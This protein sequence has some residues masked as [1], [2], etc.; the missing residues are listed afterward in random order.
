MRT[1]QKF[2]FMKVQIG[3][4]ETDPTQWDQFNT[5]ELTAAEAV[6]RESHQNS[7]DAGS[8]G[9]LVRTRIS[10]QDADPKNAAF[11]RELFA[12][13]VP[14]L[15]ACGARFLPSD[16]GMPRILV[17]ED[18]GTSGLT[19]AWDASDDLNFSDFWRRFGNSHKSG[20]SGGSW[21]LGKLAYPATSMSRT[22]FGV[23]IRKGDD[24]PLLMGQTV[25]Q[26][27]DVDSVRFVPF[28]FY[29]TLDEE[30]L[31]LPILDRD[32]I[33]QFSQ[34][35][36]FARTTEPGLSIA[37]PFV[38]TE[39]TETALIPALLRNYF[40]PI[41]TG[42]LEI[43]IGDVVIARDTFSAVVKQ[44]GGEEFAD[45]ALERFIRS[46]HETLQADA[47]AAEFPENWI[48]G[49]VDDALSPET[50]VAL[51]TKL[52]AGEIV[53]V[54]VPLKVKA[55]NSKHKIGAVDIAL[56][57]GEEGQKPRGLFVRNAITINGE[58]K[59]QYRDKPAFAALV[60]S[61]GVPAQ[62]LRASENPAH[63]D[64][65]PR[66]QK[67]GEY[68]DVDDAAKRIRQIT[69][70]PRQLC[71]L[72]IQAA[73]QRDDNALIDF[74]AIP[75]KGP[76]PGP[77]PPPPPPPPPPPSPEPYSVQKRATGFIVKGKAGEEPTPLRLTV[78]YDV[79]RGN[80]FSSFSSLDFDL[81]PTGN[82]KLQIVGADVDIVAP[83]T[84]DITPN[85]PEFSV[86]VTG[87]DNHRDLRMDIRSLA[88]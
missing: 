20:S 5:D 39:L 78:A 67:L 59:K 25:L 83:N 10:V 12:P 45:G 65:N 74:F 34:A 32:F 46:L 19:G 18:F 48:Y 72:L 2:R 35:V 64:W 27:H 71:D 4:V 1:Q 38:P 57:L 31:Q 86:E 21:G 11:F 63:T 28:G 82:L 8:T 40:F 68:W 44:Y 85:D 84:I 14:H 60:A 9:E 15:K 66:A 36:G 87:F 52:G 69:R 7:L 73:E 70:L 17:V 22:F 41:L 81:R 75:D 23:T 51:R 53:H 58:A 62:V 50:V 26:H 33:E 30:G 79:L 16:I 55:A 77:N 54:R 37:V 3:S 24:Q 76:R 43:E 13:L 29:S 49:K 80:P 42:R 56:R 6:V 47:P 61:D 88:S